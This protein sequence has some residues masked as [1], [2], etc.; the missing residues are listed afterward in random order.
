MTNN[1]PGGCGNDV[2]LDDITFRACGPLV[3]AGIVGAPDSVNVCT[4]DHSIFTLH[5]NVSSGYTDPVYQWQFTTDNGISWTNIPGATNLIYARPAI[6]APGTYLYR[7]TVSQ[8]TNMNIASCSIASNIVKIS[9]NKYPV[10]A[11]SSRGRCIGDTLSLSANDGSVFFWTGPANFISSQEFPSIPAAVAGNGGTYYVKV[12]SDKGCTSTDSVI[13][14]LSS[15]P[16][17]NAGSDTAVCEGSGIQLHSTG[18]NI[19]SYEWSPSSEISNPGIADP[20][21]R[22]DKTT[23]FILTVAHSECKVSDSVL[24]VVNKNPKADAGPDKVI[25]HGQSVVLNGTADGTDITY[26]WAPTEF[27]TAPE[28]LSPSVNPPVNENYILHV[29]SNKGCGTATD[30][31][32]VKVFEK[33][34]IPNAFTP[35]NDGINDTWF[36]ETLEAYPQAEVKVFNRYGQMVFD[37]HGINKPWNGMFKG[38]LLSPGAY[39]YL[40]DLKNNSQPV[41]GVVFIIL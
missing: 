23:V 3:T 31:V 41:K 22:P 17:V 32:K 35:N 8:R 12:T 18:N 37:N 34:F 38:T 33:L 1:A 27:I 30:T 10:P 24:I 25:I 13:V 36:I 14:N 7:L 20:V 11:A 2:L 5:A 28:T 40:I 21:A 6:T 39:V 16:V 26:K 29:T 15:K 4:G 9:V 19:T